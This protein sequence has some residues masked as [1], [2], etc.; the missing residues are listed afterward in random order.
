L[1]RALTWG[2]ST[3]FTHTSIFITLATF[4]SGDRGKKRESPW[5]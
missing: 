1:T 5:L 4:G 2:S 3:R